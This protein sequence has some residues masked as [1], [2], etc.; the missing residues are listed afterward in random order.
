MASK[1]LSL[2]QIER[3]LQKLTTKIREYVSEVELEERLTTELDTDEIWGVDASDDGYE[4]GTSGGVSSGGSG[5]ISSGTSNYE[6]LT[7]LPTINGVTL[8]GDVVSSDIL[9]ADIDHSHLYSDLIGAPT[10][11]TK[12]SQLTNDTSFITTSTLSE[13]ITKEEAY[14]ELSTKANATHEH[15]ISEIKGLQSSLDA[16][17]N[18]SHTHSTDNIDGLS[19]LLSGKADIGHKHSYASLTDKPTIPTKI[20]QL[21]DDVELISADTL[22]VLLTE[23][24]DKEHVHQVATNTTSGYMSNTDKAKLDGIDENANNYVHPNYDG[25][26]EGFYKFSVDTLGHISTTTPVATD[27]IINLI[28]DTLNLETY[29]TDAELTTALTNKA[30]ITYVDTKLADKANVSSLHTHANKTVLDDI[31][32]DKITEW[33]DKST[34]S[35]DYQDLTNK[36]MIPTNISELAN[37]KKYQTDT[38]VAEAIA[39]MANGG[40]ID[41][42]NYVTKLELEEELIGK[43]DAEHTHAIASIGNLESILANK[44]DEGHTHTLA[45]VTDLELA[46]TDEIDTLWNET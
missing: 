41:L 16:K 17:A 15:M 42:E 43:A 28:E 3:I 33:D 31:T 21:T 11:P 1:I 18:L 7:N 10:I 13:Y 44:S 20:S 39:E 2:E 24:A 29:V 37:D 6:R 12:M 38:D 8:L 46:T 40:T 9:V 22:S 35:G 19:A 34:F 27:D 30:T 32:S 26:T 45:N 14:S 23:K 36:P 4:G 5:G 25:V